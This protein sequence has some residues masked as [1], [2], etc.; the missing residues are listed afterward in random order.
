MTTALPGLVVA[1][2]HSIGRDIPRPIVV[3]AARQREAWVEIGESQVVEYIDATPG[4]A[5]RRARREPV[6]ATGQR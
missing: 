4:A 1:A 5:E 2:R 6:S 3:N